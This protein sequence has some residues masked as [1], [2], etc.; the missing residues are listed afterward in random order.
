[1]AQTIRDVMTPNPFTV[2]AGDPVVLAARTMRESDV[3]FVVVVDDGDVRGVVTDRD[4][5]VRAVADGKDPNQVKVAD[6]C[7]GEVVTLEPDASV[8]DAARLMREKAVRRVP[9]VEGSTPVGVVALGDLAVEED[10]E[11]ALADVSAAPPN[12]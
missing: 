11:S 10:P 8:E 3:G 7:S 12:N 4:I 5:A 6:I 2:E 9:V 1:M